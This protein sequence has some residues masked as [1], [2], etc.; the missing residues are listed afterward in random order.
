MPSSHA[1]L[2]TKADQLQ[3]TPESPAAPIPLLS[4]IDSPLP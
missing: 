2:Y 4:A 1:S 3:I